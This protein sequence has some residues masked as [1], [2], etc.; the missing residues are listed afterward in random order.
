MIIL[1]FIEKL[2][3][4]GQVQVMFVTKFATAAYD[5]DAQRPAQNG[6]HGNGALLT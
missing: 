3:S 1:P 5:C 6:R 2:E 4:R